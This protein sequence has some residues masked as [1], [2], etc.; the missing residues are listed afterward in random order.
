LRSF[1]FVS[2]MP[3]S[4]E[5][6]IRPALTLPGSL[7]PALRFAAFLMRKLAGGVFVSNEKHRR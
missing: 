3:R 4:A 7:E 5:R 6:L 1:I 2:A